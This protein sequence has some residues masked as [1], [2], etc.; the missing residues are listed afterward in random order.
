MVR[1][2]IYEALNSLTNYL[3]LKVV[4]YYYDDG[5]SKEL[6]CLR[7]TVAC[8]FRGI[9]YNIPIEIWFQPDHPKVPP[10]VYVKPTEYMHISPKRQDVDLDGTVVIPY[11]K[12]W[13]HVRHHFG[14]FAS[15]ILYDR[16]RRVI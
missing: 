4:P 10:L 9:R 12:S 7:G 15:L 1:R 14:V 8:R 6:L 2:D 11:L 5:T 16:S 13:R 3:V